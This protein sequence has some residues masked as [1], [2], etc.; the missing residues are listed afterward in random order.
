M[1]NAAP[2][3]LSTANAKIKKGEKAGYLTA[4]IH[5]APA[6]L[7]GHNVCPMAS[8]GCKLACLNTAGMGVYK[9]VQAAR[10]AKTQR[11]FDDR[12]NFMAQLVKEIGAIVRK[13]AKQGLIP[14][15]RLNLTSDIQWENI[16]TDGKT[17]F[18]IFPNVQFYDYTKIV[19]RVLNGS[20]AKSFPNYHLTFSRSESNDSL[21]ELAMASGANVAAVFAG[22][23]LPQTWKGR[24]VVNGETN[25]LRFLDGQ[26]VVVG[27]LTKGRAKKDTSG[28]VIQG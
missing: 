9:N 26:G 24:P 27:L 20:K 21:V 16:L 23:T 22:K 6:S 10:I 25:D 28:F 13:A 12:E 3:I 2:K 1:H 15:I 8:N 14:A 18:E 19:R 11:F 5:F 4:G 17:V 7:S